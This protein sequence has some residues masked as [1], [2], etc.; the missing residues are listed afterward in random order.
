M[1]GTGCVCHLVYKTA[2]I[3]LVYPTGFLV[4]AKI[5][6]AL[7]DIARVFFRINR[8]GINIPKKGR[9]E[10][11]GLFSRLPHTYICKI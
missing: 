8:P 10:P 1:Q 2:R 3:R 4:I 6:Y 9:P 5:K 11:H 7:N